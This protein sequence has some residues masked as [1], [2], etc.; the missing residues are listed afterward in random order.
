MVRPSARVGLILW[1]FLS[2][3]LGGPLRAGSGESGL[4]PFALPNGLTGAIREAHGSPMVAALVTVEAGTYV[5]TPEMVGASHML[6]HLLFDGTES[7]SREEITERTRRL[8]IYLNAFTRKDYTAFI[9]LAPKESFAEGLEILADMLFRSILPEKEVDKEREV[10]IEEIRRDRSDPGYAFESLLEANFFSGMLARPVLGSEAVIRTIS[11]RTLLDYYRRRYRPSR[12]RMILVG[13]VEVP[14]ALD[15]LRRT[16]GVDGGAVEAEAA[17]S[18]NGGRSLDGSFLVAAGEGGTTR[19]ALALPGPEPATEEAVAMELFC[20]YASR[21]GSPLDELAKRSEWGVVDWSLGAEGHRGAGRVILRVEAR[22]ARP[23]PLR[24]A[25]L[26]AIRRTAKER[27]DEKAFERVRTA[28]LAERVYRSE[29]YHYYGFFLAPEL[30]MGGPDWLARRDELLRELSPEEVRRVARRYLAGTTWRAV[31]MVPRDSIRESEAR[32]GKERTRR[33]VLDN[34][35]R[36]VITQDDASEVFAAHVVAGHRLACEPESLGG[37]TEVLFRL[38][39]RGGDLEQRLQAIG[40]RLETVDNPYIPYDD[41]RT[42]LDYA[43][44]RFQTID[45]YW[46]EGTALLS[47]ILARRRFEREDLEAAKREVTG[48]IERRDR[49]PSKLARRVFFERLFAGTPFGRDVLGTAASI[50]RIDLADVEAFARSF[51]DPRNL[52]L[53]IQTHRPLEEVERWVRERFGALPGGEAACPSVAVSPWR[54]ERT[55]TVTLP[56]ARQAAIV[57]G[58]TL[59]GV[60]REDYPALVVLRS[61]LARRL[62]EVLRER[63][64]LA[65]SVTADAYL[66]PALG[67]FVVRMCTGAEKLEAALAGIDEVLGS[68][69]AECD[70]DEVEEVVAAYRGRALMRR[71]A[72][73]NRAYYAGLNELRGFGYDFDRSL[74]EAIRRV[75]PEDVQRLAKR[76]LPRENRCIVVVRPR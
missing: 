41:Y 52:I 42:R 4:V 67:Y 70:S 13:D 7:H 56:G 22:S 43:F 69:E 62:A 49:T 23:R 59:E 16:F 27:G 57:V 72:R 51:L 47:E 24:E 44:L 74:D 60:G 55:E 36:V 65:Y 45:R 9:M 39:A 5:E 38:L 6:E 17:A 33:F 50:S 53:T 48:A 29:Q 71:L 28:M 58:T 2:T 66:G 21:A 68:I 31:A 14:E 1:A 35:L 61:V 3:V 40:A 18:G 54:G 30:A 32:G 10:V 37:V 11:R 20:R 25:M 8:G 15:L 75:R 34:G 19:I 26:E 76:V 73:I 46:R 64:G 12:M 63:R